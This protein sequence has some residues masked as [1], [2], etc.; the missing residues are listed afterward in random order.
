MHV[1]VRG[2][3]WGKFQYRGS[4]VKHLD[5]ARSIWWGVCGGR[6]QGNLD[7]ERI[8]VGCN[9]D[10]SPK[11]ALVMSERIARYISKYMTK[12][13]LFE[14]RPDKKRYWC[15]E[16]SLPDARRFW[17]EVRPNGIETQQ[18]DAL[19]ECVRRLDIDLSCARVFM[20]PDGSG[21][22]LSYNPDE[23]AQPQPP[24]F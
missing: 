6:G 18:A 20:F 7:I 21:F 16:F 1:A 4:Y 22:W 15:S 3:M 2:G 13:L 19:T 10:G 24:P 5:L 9:S 14:H 23:R 17:L 11:G 12:Q 8:K